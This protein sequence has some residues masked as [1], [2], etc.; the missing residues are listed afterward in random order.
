MKVTIIGQQ[1]FGSD[2][3]SATSQKLGCTEMLLRRTG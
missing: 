1:D 2:M 3:A